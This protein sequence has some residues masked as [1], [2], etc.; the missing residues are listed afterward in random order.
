MPT[1]RLLAVALVASVLA[2][3][4]GGDPAAPETPAW[5]HDP[6]DA[7]GPAGWGGVDASYRQCVDGTRQS[8]I[9]L[10]GAVRRELPPLRFD[11]A[12]APLTVENTGHTV[13]VP[14]PE[15]G[16]H[17]LTVGGDEYRLVQ[18]HFHTPS[19]HTVGG[20]RFALEAHL[21][22]EDAAGRL[23][24]VAVFL[25]RSRPASPLVESVLSE[26]PDAAGEETEPGSRASAASLLPGGAGNGPVTIRRY[27]TYGGSLTTP[28]CSEGVRWLVLAETLGVSGGATD[29]LQELVAGF[30]GYDG[31]RRNNRPTQPLNGRRVATTG[32]VVAAD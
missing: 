23:A 30:P 9:E 5:S 25:D 3:C 18:Y 2:G 17:T 19:E 24:V 11:Y 31:Y 32:R 22:H 7:S 20:R 4:G 10:G 13:E 12:A 16:T 21:V 28:D 15:G 6:A 29:R 14:M 27:T 1:H 8:P 26:A